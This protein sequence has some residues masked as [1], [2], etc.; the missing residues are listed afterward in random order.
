MSL[1]SKK[2]SSEFDEQPVSS[3]G[4]SKAPLLVLL[5]LVGVFAYLYFFTSLIVPHEAPK[6]V[7]QTSAPEV[8]QSMPPKPAAVTT[9]AAPA[10]PAA[11]PAPAAPAPAAKPAPPA[12][13]P[14]PAAKPA[15]PAPAA[16]PAATVPAAKPAPAAPAAAGAQKAAPPAASGSKKEDAK[17][18]KPAE[19]KAAAAAGK[20]ESAKTDKPAKAA[21]K[22]AA[23][24]SAEYIVFA[25]EFSAGDE[26]DAAEA[27]LVAAGVKP[28]VKSE[29]KKTRTMNR[30]FFGAYAD[31]DNYRA[32]LDKLKKGAKGAFG[33]EKDGKYY[34]YAGSFSTKEKAEKEKKDLAAK[35]ISLQ[36]QQ[37]VLTLKSVRLSAGNFK[38]KAD[39]DKAAAKL[40]QAGLNVKVLPKGE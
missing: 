5:L 32:E 10:A 14:A 27:K 7:E 4:K 34:L 37:A 23:K 29:K 38:V 20:K 40:K 9:A 15:A 13:A 3:S 39:A 17:P 1:F 8:K 25:G 26:S 6:T 33:V 18:V 22:S 24:K 28:V 19:A 16:K 2:S 36:V 11:A 30:L 35:G 21:A 31:Y 12:P